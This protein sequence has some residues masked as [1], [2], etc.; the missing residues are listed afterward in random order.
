MSLNA[1]LR[2][3]TL[4][5]IELLSI[6]PRF[7]SLRALARA[8]EQEAAQITRSIKRIEGLLGFEVLNRTTSGSS[9]TE[10]GLKTSQRANVVMN[11]ARLLATEKTAQESKLV[12]NLGARA[13][14]NS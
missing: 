11:S 13:F 12:L 3:L 5:D 14:L 2:A 7:S 9:L 10:M 1:N 6:L 4:Q 8:T